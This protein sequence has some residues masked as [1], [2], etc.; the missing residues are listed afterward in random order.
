[1][2]IGCIKQAGRILEDLATW[3]W[4]T[5]TRSGGMMKEALKI[6]SNDKLLTLWV[7]KDQIIYSS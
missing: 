3:L 4:K 6:I 7:L 5:N 1:M 2:R